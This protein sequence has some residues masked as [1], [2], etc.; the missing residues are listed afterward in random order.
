M[1]GQTIS[2]YKIL[3]QLGAGRMG[4]V[5]GAED[6]KLKRP[7]ALKLL[8]PELTQDEVARTRF[9]YEAQ[10]ASA[11]DHPNVCT[12]YE[13]DETRDG[14]M[15][16][17]MAHYDGESLK[18]RLTRGALPVEEAI[19][20]ATQVAEGLAQVHSQA[21]IHRDINPAN[22]I[23]TK[24][25]IVKIV[26]FGVAKLAGPSKSSEVRYPVGTIAYMSP[27]Q[28][29]GEDVD[30]RTDIWSLGVVVYEMVT[31]KWP[32]TGAYDQAVIYSILSEDPPP[33]TAVDTSLPARLEGIVNKALA[34]AVVDRYQSATEMIADLESLKKALESGASVVGAAKRRP[35]PSIAVLPF[36]DMSAD[37][38]QEHFCDG[39]VEDIINHLTHIKDMRVAARTSA[40]AFKDTNMDA[41]EIGKALGVDVLLE[42][43]V[44]KAENRLRITAQLVNVADGYHLWSDRYDR[45]ASDVF[46]IQDEIAYNITRA[47]EIKLSEGERETLAKAPT[48]DVVAYDF[49]LRGRR[50]FHQK[51]PASIRQALEM[52]TL[53][54]DK[55]PNYALAHSGIADCYSYISLFEDKEESLKR[56][57]RAGQRALEFD[58]DLAEAH[59]TR[60]L[61]LSLA[62]RDHDEVDEA[63][64]TAIQLNPA[65]FEAYYFYG[66]SCRIQRR[67]EKA[68]Q[69]FE[70]AAVIYPEDYQSQ[71]HLGMAYKTLNLAEKTVEAYRRSLLNV[72]RHLELNPEDSRARQMG[73]VALI[74]L[75][76]P[77]KGLEWGARAVTMDPENPI[78][79]YNSACVFS[80]AGDT[81][82]A[83]ACLEKAVDTGYSNR[84]ALLNDPDLDPIRNDPRVQKLVKRL[85]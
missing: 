41:R 17:C 54:T 63:F 67:W 78:L 51:R 12:I 5:Y 38:D 80:A 35:Q 27:E 72:E 28:A 2:H 13:V 69:L 82:R 16:I 26:D 76:D 44:R 11:L 3:E 53:A 43:S 30:H 49:Y 24:S 83:I 39:I 21:I 37:A 77:E 84:G 52:F 42:G 14:Q 58:P 62:G 19:D 59:A 36:V 18:Q 68:A 31:A 55:D 79:L 66:Y 23:V 33:I 9:I 4:V 34:K 10:T 70:K 85:S 48:Q 40:F 65:L 60:G 57:F 61:T 25:G 1:I 46:T 6:T 15:F 50:L 74:E 75:G 32:F 56:S 64:E 71:Y 7:V 20:I 22:L 8:P 81:E 45:E 47:L 29:R 73:A